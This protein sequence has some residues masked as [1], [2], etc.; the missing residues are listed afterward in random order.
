MAE[1]QEMFSNPVEGADNTDA[2][3][4]KEASRIKITDA[5]D[6]AN[7]VSFKAFLKAFNDSYTSNWNETTVYARMDPIYTF[8]NTTRVIN[9]EIDIPAYDVHEAV[10]NLQ[11][12]SRLVR[13]LYPSYTS[14]KTGTLMTAA[15]VV[16][17]KFGNL[18]DDSSGNSKIGLYG[19]L[20]GIA[21]NPDTDAGFFTGHNAESGINIAPKLHRLTCE[22][23]PLHSHVVGHD[24]TTDFT[25]FPYKTEEL[26]GITTSMQGT[27]EGEGTGGPSD[28][29]DALQAGVLGGG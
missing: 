18:I 19:I 23:K 10:K 6:H 8:Q 4:G 14:V 11:N 24:D 27:I 21:V 22:F 7:S 5:R 15:P 13:M 2:I 17:I 26:L 29:L 1:E 3:Y 28:I 9:F 16:A 12:L 20:S 25:Q